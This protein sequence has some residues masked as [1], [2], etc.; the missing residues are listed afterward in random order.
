MNEPIRVTTTLESR[1]DAERLAT[2]LLKRRLVE[3]AQIN[4]PVRSLYW[5][6]EEIAQSDEFILSVKTFGE[7]YKKVETLIVDEHPYDV[8]KK[9][10]EPL[11]RVSASYLQ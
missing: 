9:V 2:L 3:C 6:Q 11:N 4:G 5:W 10:A 8:P 7:V 1:E